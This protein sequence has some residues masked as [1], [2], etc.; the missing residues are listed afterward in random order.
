[1]RKAYYDKTSGVDWAGILTSL[2]TTA[3]DKCAE[4]NHG[5]APDECDEVRRQLQSEVGRRNQV[6]EYFGPNGLQAPFLRG[7]Q[8]GALVDLAAIGDQIR[9]EV[10]PPPAENGASHV[11][12]VITF[13]IK[14]A[15]ASSIVCAPC[16]A[17]AGGLGG[18]FGLAAYLTK[19]DGSPDIIGPKVTTAAAKLGGELFDRYQRVSAYLETE[20]KIII[21]DYDKLTEVATRSRSDWALGGDIAGV[22]NMIRLATRQ[23]IYKALVPVAWPVS[24]TSAGRR[25]RPPASSTTPRSGTATAARSCTTSTSSRTP[26]PV[27]RSSGG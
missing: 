12:D 5:F 8:S 24:T 6:A 14:I 18:A 22:T 9:S 3:R 25:R 13:M 10:K 1:M 7:V 16:G 11:L 19:Q 23:T 2:G 26:V 20:A 4:P 15:S 17:A 21:S 27:R